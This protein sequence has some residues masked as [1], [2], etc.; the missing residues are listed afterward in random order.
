MTTTKQYIH[1]Q[2]N[3]TNKKYSLNMR[4][5]WGGGWG[6]RRWGGA[7]EGTMGRPGQH[8]RRWRRRRRGLEAQCVSEWNV[9][10]HGIKLPYVWRLSWESSDIRLSPTACLTTVGHKVMSDS[11]TDCRRMYDLMSDGCR[12]PSDITLCLMAPKGAVGDILTII[13]LCFFCYVLVLK[14]TSER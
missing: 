4:W 9:G 11:L 5:G 7:S 2:N 12:K 13:C 8:R 14:W 10:R 1:I 6:R 3:T